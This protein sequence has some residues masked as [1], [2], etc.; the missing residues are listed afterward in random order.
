MKRVCWASLAVA[1]WLCAVTLA[2]FLLATKGPI[3][4]AAVSFYSQKF[5]LSCK[6]EVSAQLPEI[7]DACDLLLLIRFARSW[8][9]SVPST[10]YRG[11]FCFLLCACSV[12]SW[13][14]VSSGRLTAISLEARITSVAGTSDH[15]QG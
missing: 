7:I 10:V 14:D 13:C 11:A 1:G 6:S 15:P 2:G 12:C 4:A 8:D 9:G 5:E 3:G